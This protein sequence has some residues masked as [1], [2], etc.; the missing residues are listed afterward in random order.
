MRTTQPSILSHWEPHWVNFTLIFSRMCAQSWGA[1]RFKE[2]GM[3]KYRKEDQLP[4]IGN[5]KICEMVCITWALA[6]HPIIWHFQWLTA[7]L[8]ASRTESRTYLNL[9][10]IIWESLP[11]NTVSSANCEWS[12]LL[13]PRTIWRP[14]RLPTSHS[15]SSLRLKESAIMINNMGERGQ[16]WCNPLLLW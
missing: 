4:T 3:R 16:R 14:S 10:A 8:E 5:W 7:F 15:C 1:K 13:T 9:V 12:R 11:R 2:I 6:F